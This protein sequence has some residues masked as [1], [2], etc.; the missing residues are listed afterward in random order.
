M[1]N[2]IVTIS[3]GLTFYKVGRNNVTYFTQRRIK[4]TIFSHHTLY[5]YIYIYIYINADLDKFGYK[6]LTGYSNKD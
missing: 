5:I 2:K 1:G 4:T 6:L 3:D